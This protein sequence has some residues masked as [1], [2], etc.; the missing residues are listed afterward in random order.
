MYS[1]LYIRV[2]TLVAA[3]ML[4]LSAHATLISGSITGGGNYSGVVTR[5]DAWVLSNPIDGD[6]V[7]FWTLSGNMG[8]SVSIFVTSS[9]IEFGVSLFQG[10]VDEFELL[11]PGFN[12]TGDF[13]DNILVASTPGFGTIGTQLLNI[14]LPVSGIYTLAVGGEAFSPFGSSF[15]Y[16]MDIKVKPVPMPASMCLLIIGLLL[17]NIFGRHRIS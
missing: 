14:I 17:M 16:N 8:D 13:A 7:N 6:E 3:L 1:S 15:A 5:S 12:N 4:S 2:V 9:D 11:V 10:L